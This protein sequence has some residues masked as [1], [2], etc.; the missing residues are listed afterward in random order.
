MGP[1]GDLA[2]GIDLSIPVG[3]GLAAVLYP[4]LLFAFPEPRD[5]YGPD[6]SR[7]V[8]TGPPAGIPI[9]SVDDDRSEPEEVTVHG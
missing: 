5:A 7:F 6:G 1:L 3:L 9:T 4:V 2:D 8:P